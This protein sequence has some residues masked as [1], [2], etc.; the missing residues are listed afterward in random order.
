MPNCEHVP[1]GIV[2]NQSPL[3]GWDRSRAHA[4]IVSCDRDACIADSIAWVIRKTK[5]HSAAF[6]SYEFIRAAKKADA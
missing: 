5:E 3:E 4:S 2:T 1:K 6:Y